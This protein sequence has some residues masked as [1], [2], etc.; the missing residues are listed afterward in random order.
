MSSSLIVWS[1]IHVLVCHRSKHVGES[2][3]AATSAWNQQQFCGYRYSG[4]FLRSDI[5][6]LWLLSLQTKVCAKKA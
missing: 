6:R 5:H 1:L 3:L 4:A 2:E